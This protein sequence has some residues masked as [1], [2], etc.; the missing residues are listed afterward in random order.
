MLAIRGREEH[1]FA[2]DFTRLQSLEY[3]VW[4]GWGQCFGWNRTAL[5]EKAVQWRYHDVLGL[6]GSLL[7]GRLRR[8]LPPTDPGLAEQCCEDLACQVIAGLI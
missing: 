6:S 1:S 4:P 7:S 3:S 8:R 2:H 5:R